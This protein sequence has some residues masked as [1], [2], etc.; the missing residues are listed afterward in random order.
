MELSAR[1]FHTGLNIKTSCM[2]AGDACF[3]ITGIQT[4]GDDKISTSSPQFYCDAYY[5]KTLVLLRRIPEVLSFNTTFLIF[6]P[7]KSLVLLG[8][9]KFIANKGT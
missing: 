2:Q 4:A 8:G 9:T 3:A 7:E 1:N 6:T 5:L